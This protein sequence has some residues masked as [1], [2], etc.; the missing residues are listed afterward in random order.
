MIGSAQALVLP[1][2]LESLAGRMEVLTFWPFSQGEIG[3]RSE[4]LVD[5]CFASGRT[6]MPCR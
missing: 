4:G 5:A 6:F 2:V 3:G 1:K